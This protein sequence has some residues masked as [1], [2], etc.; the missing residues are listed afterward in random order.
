MLPFPK[1]Y[2]QFY[3]LYAISMFRPRL[4]HWPATYKNTEITLSLVQGC[5]VSQLLHSP[6]NVREKQTLKPETELLQYHLKHEW[7]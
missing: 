5:L 3:T 1:P 6:L 7:G 2:T 4:N